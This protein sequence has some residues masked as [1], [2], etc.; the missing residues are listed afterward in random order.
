[1]DCSTPGFPVLHYFPE[2]T[3]TLVHW[4][5]DAIQPSR[6]LSSPSPPTLSLSQN[7]GHFQCVG[8]V[9]Q[10]ANVLELQLQHQSFN[11]YLG[12]IS[13]R[14]YWSLLFK[15]LSRMF[16]SPTV[17]RHQVFD[18]QPFSLSSSH[19]P[20]WLLEKPELWL[21]GPLPKVSKRIFLNNFLKNKLFKDTRVPFRWLLT[22]LYL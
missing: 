18:A 15:G 20:T 17:W 5:S 8:S 10:V 13:L 9:N 11:E 21:H 4:V 3:Q 7:P 2:F 12:L 14:I 1:M 16:S 22:F 19:I 6:P